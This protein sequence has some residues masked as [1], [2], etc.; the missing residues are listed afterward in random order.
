MTTS[1]LTLPRPDFASR[2]ISVLMWCAGIFTILSAVS[3][4]G[5]LY[6]AFDLLSHFRLHFCGVAL[7]LAAMSCVRRHWIL[8]A[9][10]AAGCI[11]H[12]WD[13]ASLYRQRLSAVPSA[14]KVAPLRLMSFNAWLPNSDAARLQAQVMAERPDVLFIAELSDALQAGMSELRQ[15][16]PYQFPLSGQN[17]NAL[18]IFSRYPWHDAG[19]FVTGNDPKDPV[20]IKATLKTPQGDLTVV[21]IHTTS[22]MSAAR[23]RH[24]NMQFRKIANYLRNLPQPVVVM[25]DYNATPWSPAYRQYLTTTGFKILEPRD[26]PVLTWPQWAPGIFRIPIDH[27]TASDGV[28]VVRKQSLDSMGSDHRAVLAEIRL[29]PV[30]YT[31]RR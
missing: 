3:F 5:R 8:A 16:Y 23:W 15:E 6:W 11:L 4:A 2:R 7:M 12:G 1:V 9:V 21:G 14:E 28:A 27:L 24:R 31:S 29:L 19:R 10:F 17:W 13:A 25:G 18:G 26:V 22:P 20:V 30:K